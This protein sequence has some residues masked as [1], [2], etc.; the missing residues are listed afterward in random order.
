[1]RAIESVQSSREQF[2]LGVLPLPLQFCAGNLDETA[3]CIEPKRVMAIKDMRENA[4]ARQAVAD[5]KGL[6]FAFLPRDDAGSCRSQHGAVGTH[7]ELFYRVS[8][9]VARIR[10][11]FE[12]AVPIPSQIAADQS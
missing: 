3:R 4:V 7:S 9:L 11:N 8:R 10:K 6:L 1:M 5:H 12:M 2:G